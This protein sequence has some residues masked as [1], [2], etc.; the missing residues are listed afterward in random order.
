MMWINCLRLSN[1]TPRRSTS[2]L[3]TG[4]NGSTH[5]KLTAHLLVETHR[6]VGAMRKRFLARGRA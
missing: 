1:E 2:S 4:G 5:P 6:I 3:A